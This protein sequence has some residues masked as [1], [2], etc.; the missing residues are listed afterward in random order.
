MNLTR[1]FIYFL[2]E[3]LNLDLAEAQKVSS[4]RILTIDSDRIN[5]GSENWFIDKQKRNIENKIAIILGYNYKEI[6]F[7]DKS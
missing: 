3:L 7:K 4:T 2:S 5:T 1:Y 6:R